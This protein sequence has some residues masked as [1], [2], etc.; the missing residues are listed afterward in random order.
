MSPELHLMVA[1][2]EF[3]ANNRNTRLQTYFGEIALYDN[4]VMAEP[5][6]EE[7]V[8]VFKNNKSFDQ[9][10]KA[11]LEHGFPAY[12][13]LPE[14]SEGIVEAYLS[15]YNGDLDTLDGGVPDEWTKP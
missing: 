1:G 2:E 13:N 6:S 7:A 3:V 12:L 11:L 15:Q 14:V 9:L 8:I 5:D 4:V 10:A